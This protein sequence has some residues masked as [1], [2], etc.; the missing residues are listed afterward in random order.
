MISTQPTGNLRQGREPQAGVIY[1]LSFELPFSLAF[2]LVG[3]IHSVC[4]SCAFLK[5]SVQ[6]SILED[7]KYT[8]PHRV[9]LAV[10]VAATSPHRVIYSLYFLSVG[11]AASIFCIFACDS[12]QFISF[13]GE[14]AP[15]L[16]VRI[17]FP[18]SPPQR[19]PLF[20]GI[21]Q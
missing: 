18:S 5:Y 11:N 9:G 6:P 7:A 17:P 16:L 19:S 12:S 1:F 4:L 21:C 13:S 15:I 14:C 8:S 20:P 2:V 10:M 3:P